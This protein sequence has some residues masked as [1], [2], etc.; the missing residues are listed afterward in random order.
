[1]IKT[2]F[3]SSADFFSIGLL[4]STFF[5]PYKQISA[6]SAT[7]TFN[8]QIRAFF[9]KLLSRIIGATVR[10]FMIIVGLI[11]IVSQFI[12]GIITCITWVIVPILPVAGVILAIIGWV[13]V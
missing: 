13:P 5:S 7:E 2:R 12:F 10:S 3:E 6:E 8:Q 4:F 11:V 9:D 1:M